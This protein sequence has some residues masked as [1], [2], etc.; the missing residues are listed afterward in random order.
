M[1]DILNV[2]TT[3]AESTA[4]SVAYA[5]N[6]LLRNETIVNQRTILRILQDMM[7][8]IPNSGI[9]SS[10]VGLFQLIHIYK[11]NILTILL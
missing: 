10:I 1:N 2:I 7:N 3:N 6:S 4:V 11:Q 8:E 9:L 5:A